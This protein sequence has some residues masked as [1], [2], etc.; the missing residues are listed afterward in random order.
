MVV[1]TKS[2]SAEPILPETFKFILQT[3]PGVSMKYPIRQFPDRLA[4]IL[5]ATYRHLS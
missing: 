2:F 5:D 3:R 1:S 4:L